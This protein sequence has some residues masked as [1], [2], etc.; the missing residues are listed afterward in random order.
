MIVSQFSPNSVVVA[1]RFL[2]AVPLALVV[3]EID[4]YWVIALILAGNVGFDP[5]DT[6]VSW[7]CRDDLLWGDDDAPSL[8]AGGRA[9]SR[10]DLTKLSLLSISLD[11]ILDLPSLLLHRAL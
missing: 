5:L 11:N 9:A 4:E 8:G 2:V 7:C 3:V 1:N 6:F 10:L